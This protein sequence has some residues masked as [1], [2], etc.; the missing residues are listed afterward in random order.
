MGSLGTPSA[1][2]FTTITFITTI[3]ALTSGLITQCYPVLDAVLGHHA[4][5]SHP[6]SHTITLFTCQGSWAPDQGRCREVSLRPPSVTFIIHSVPLTLCFTVFPVMSS[7]SF[8]FSLYHISQLPV[9]TFPL[10]LSLV[11]IPPGLTND[12][13]RGTI[14]GRGALALGCLCFLD[15]ELE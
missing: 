7:L 10:F 6:A 8:S 11:P 13:S 3:T 2:A 9:V 14:I 4:M 1:T 5:L 15:L 12:R